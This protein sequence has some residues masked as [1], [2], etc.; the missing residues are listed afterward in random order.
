MKVIGYFS[1]KGGAG[2]STLASHSAVIA[3]EQNKVALVDADPQGNV[4]AWGEDR[5]FAT[6]FVGVVTPSTILD[7]L[8]AAQ[9]D[10]YEYV[11]V[12]FPPHADAGV[13]GLVSHMDF[14]VVPC[15]PTP[16]DYLTLPA[17][18]AILNAHAKPFGFV[19]NRIG[20]KAAGRKAA[21]TT[22]LSGY[23]AVCPHTLASLDAYPDAWISGRA[24][25]EYAPGTPAA[26]DIRAV[27]AWIHN[28][29]NEVSHA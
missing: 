20:R 28:A 14:V 8:A 15:Q 17:T 25:T 7:F 4:S 10:D 1:Q 27:W 19:I 18:C 29:V 3:A 11:M 24:V 2:K 21:A 6:P 16:N 23:G 9:A 5:P 26:D 13:A 12:D 22:L